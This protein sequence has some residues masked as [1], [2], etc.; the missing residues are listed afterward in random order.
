[1]S[2]ILRILPDR[3]E[4]LMGFVYMLGGCMACG[5]TFSYNPNHVPSHNNEPVCADCMGI[6]NK[7]RQD[8]GLP[9]HAIHAQAYEPLPD[10]EL[11]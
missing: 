2:H 1:M 4:I 8:Q 10:E 6:V 9:E 3:V 5:K 11:R 7:A